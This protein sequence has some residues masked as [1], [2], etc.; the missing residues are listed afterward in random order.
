MSQHAGISTVS[1]TTITVP[2]YGQIGLQ[3][4]D[5]RKVKGQT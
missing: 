4:G 3:E 1:L 2:Y 5:S